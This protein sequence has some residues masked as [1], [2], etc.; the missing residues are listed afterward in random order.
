MARLTADRALAGGL[1]KPEEAERLLEAL[2][3]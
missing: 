2:A 1:L 3:D